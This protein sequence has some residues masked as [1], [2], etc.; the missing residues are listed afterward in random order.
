MHTD[1]CGRLVGQ[2]PWLWRP[3][4]PPLDFLHLCPPLWGRLVACAGLVGPLFWRAKRPPASFA[5]PSTFYIWRAG[6]LGSFCNFLA[7]EA[8]ELARSSPGMM[9]VWGLRPWG[10]S[11]PGGTALPAA[12]RGPGEFFSRLRGW[13]GCGRRWSLCCPW[14]FRWRAECPLLFVRIAG[15]SAGSGYDWA[16]VV[17]RSG[18]FDSFR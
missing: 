11:V 2:P 3:L 16:Q 5:R 9:W 15:A 1:N 8:R 13:R 12:V 18:G 4:R 14:C 6:R 7:A 17:G 10:E